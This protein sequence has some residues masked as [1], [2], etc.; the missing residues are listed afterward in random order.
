MRE[1]QVGD[2]IGD[3]NDIGVPD[4]PYMGYLKDKDKKFNNDIVEDFKLYI[5]NARDFYNMKEYETAFY[6]LDY[7]FRSY[8]KM[9]NSEKS[10]VRYNPDQN[11]IIELCCQIF[12]N[13]GKYQL[14]AI[15]F[16]IKNKYPFKLCE[17]CDCIYPINY[18]YCIKCGKQLNKSADVKSPEIIAEELS[19]L[20]RHKIWDELVRFD[21]VNRSLVLMKSNDC[22]LVK[23]ADRYYGLDFIFEKEHKYFKTTYTCEYIPGSVRIFDDYGVTHNHDKLLRD[24]SF[25]NLIKDTENKTGFTFIECGGGYGSQLDDNR[26]DFIF[27]DNIYVFVR[28]DMGDGKIAVYDV[29]LDNMQLSKD[30]RV[31]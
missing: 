16:I 7:A 29:D 22:R 13:H 11:W 21:L 31:Y 30:Y 5:N 15:D 24:E 12:N 4:I 8:V 19:D 10:R 28:F 14:E 2:N 18:N 23:I 1:W 26:F 3:G 25:K 17:D 9:N 6:Y 20:L 27:N